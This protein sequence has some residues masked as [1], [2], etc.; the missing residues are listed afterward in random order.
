MLHLKT[1][2]SDQRE[3]P[4]AR[5]LLHQ[6]EPQADDG[7]ECFIMGRLTAIV[8]RMRSMPVK[9]DFET[10]LRILETFSITAVPDGYRSSLA[11]SIPTSSLPRCLPFVSKAFGVKLADELASLESA[12]NR[13]RF[14]F[15][16]IE[17]ET[18]F[19]VSPF[20]IAYRSGAGVV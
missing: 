1:P 11:L 15:L 17:R 14:V 4:Y 18:Q 10:I 13:Y 9:R 12:G 8:R 7:Q 19:A 3:V 16:E 20:A 5:S 2:F 6:F